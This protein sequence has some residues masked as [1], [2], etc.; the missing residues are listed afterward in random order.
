V[1]SRRAFCTLAFSGALSISSV[2]LR[3]N[4]NLPQAS[5]GE[6]PQKIIQA[7]SSYPTG[8]EVKADEENS[9]PLILRHDF[10]FDIMKR[11]ATKGPLLS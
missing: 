10:R 9:P 2:I 6:T 3:Q 1:L 11:C 7:S 8:E 4:P 5:K